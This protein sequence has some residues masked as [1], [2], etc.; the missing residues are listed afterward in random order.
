MSRILIK[1]ACILSMDPTIGDLDRGDLLII[2]EHIAEVSP[3]IDAETDRVINGKDTIVLPG[4]INAHVH[5]WE[6]ATKCDGHT[7]FQI[8]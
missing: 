8:S 2:D 6:T 4:L 3:H 1:D 5:T 7:T